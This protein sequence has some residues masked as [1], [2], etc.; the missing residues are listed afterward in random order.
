MADN[1]LHLAKIPGMAPSLLF[2]TTFT[3]TR[4][5]YQLIDSVAKHHENVEVTFLL[6]DQD[7]DFSPPPPEK[8]LSIIHRKENQVMSLS[9]ARN[10]AID[11]VKELK[12]EADFV[13]YPDDDNTFDAHFFGPFCNFAAGRKNP[14]M[15]R[16]KNADDHKDYKLFNLENGQMLDKHH[17]PYSMSYNMVLP[18]QVFLA[19]GKF[20]ERLGVG[21]KYGSSEDVDYYLKC[22]AVAPF[23]FV[24]NCW[25][26]HPSRDEKYNQMSH[27]QIWKR[28]SSYSE[29]YY[30]VMAKNS[31]FGHLSWV[32]LR[33]L[34]GI[35]VYTLRGELKMA[36][37]YVKLFFYRLSLLLKFYGLKK[38]N[39]TF[40]EE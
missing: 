30:F 3:H 19:A 16:V 36:W 1:A 10:L 25:L 7:T 21:A 39:P 35:P 33:S 31:R 38:T 29:G 8:G 23:K 12:I 9:K 24:K 2:I 11:L 4:F 34:G 22:V 17:A 40:F 37:L 15:I 32:W 6:I 18:W 28:F 14:V 13:M 26:Y 27:A 20:D 5:V